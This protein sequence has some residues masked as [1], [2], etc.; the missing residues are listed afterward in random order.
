[1]TDGGRQLPSEHYFEFRE[2]EDERITLVDENDVD[3]IAESLRKNR[4]QLK[5]S[6]SGAEHYHTRSHGPQD[7]TIPK[8]LSETESRPEWNATRAAAA[9]RDRSQGS[10][11]ASL[12]RSRQMPGDPA[13]IDRAK[14][15][16]G[17]D[18]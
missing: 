5:A 6:K 8:E 10:N 15:R 3:G 17:R 16:V 18:R 2:A 11:S 7:I 14:R 13:R 4:R 1:M 12:G 9:L